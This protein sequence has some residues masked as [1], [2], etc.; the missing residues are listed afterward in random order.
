MFKEGE[1]V[2]GITLFPEAFEIEE[3]SKKGTIDQGELKSNIDLLHIVSG[4]QLLGTVN[5]TSHQLLPPVQ[6]ANS[7]ANRC[8][9]SNH[10]TSSSS[11]TNT[12]ENEDEHVKVERSISESSS[13]SVT[14]KASTLGGVFLDFVGRTF[15]PSSPLTTGRGVRHVTRTRLPTKDTLELTWRNR[16]AAKA[17]RIFDPKDPQNMRITFEVTREFLSKEDAAIISDTLNDGVGAASASSPLGSE[18][19]G[20]MTVA[21]LT[22]E[23]VSFS[24]KIRYTLRDGKGRETHRVIRYDTSCYV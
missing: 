6:Q 13:S 23:E 16:K 12:E 21:Q 1:Q 10:L 19:E 7:S 3:R 11:S 17:V 22:A 2:D 24:G 4:R 5:W 15:G 9:E 14:R 8:I 20:Y 18:S